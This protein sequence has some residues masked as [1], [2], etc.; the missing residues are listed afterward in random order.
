MVQGCSRLRNSSSVF[1]ST[2]KNITPISISLL[3]LC[4]GS[5]RHWFQTLGLVHRFHRGAGENSW[6][7]YCRQLVWRYMK[8]ILYDQI[9]PC[10]FQSHLLVPWG[11]VVCKD[12]KGRQNRFKAIL[13]TGA[14]WRM[15]FGE[16]FCDGVGCLDVGDPQ[17]YQ[18]CDDWRLNTSCLYICIY[19]A[20]TCKFNSSF[21]VRYNVSLTVARHVSWIRSQHP[22]VGK[23]WKSVL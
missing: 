23:C 11:R 13:L 15:T 10:L 4:E 12:P 1:K 8:R 3:A 14:C 17:R 6:S 21:H 20:F 16:R 5:C 22:N 9:F 7:T 2:N 18:R 19:L